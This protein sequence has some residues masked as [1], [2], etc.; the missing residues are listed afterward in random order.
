MPDD[1]GPREARRLFSAAEETPC[2]GGIGGLTRGFRL[3][4]TTPRASN[5]RDKLRTP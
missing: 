4:Q 1:A 5:P 2:E 3:A